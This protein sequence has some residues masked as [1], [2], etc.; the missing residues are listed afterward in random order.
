VAANVH[1]YP[2]TAIV[3]RRTYREGAAVVSNSSKEKSNYEVDPYDNPLPDLQTA[4]PPSKTETIRTDNSET[5]AKMVRCEHWHGNIWD[6]Y[7]SDCPWCEIS[8]LQA[9]VERLT[10]ERDT[11][12]S[13]VRQLEAERD[14]LRATLADL[15][16]DI[17]KHAT[18]TVWCGP[19]ETACDRITAGLGDEWQQSREERDGP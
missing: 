13:W 10:R 8:R 7:S 6:G 15:R 2:E 9:E 17:A 18:D 16:S 5:D 12:C 4:P 3:L 14:R 1:N 19:A 11:A